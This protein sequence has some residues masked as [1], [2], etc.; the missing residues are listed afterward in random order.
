MALSAQL[1]RCWCHAS[2]FRAHCLLAVDMEFDCGC[3]V[4]N[5]VRFTFIVFACETSSWRRES[6]SV[7]LASLGIPRNDWLSGSPDLGVQISGTEKGPKLQT[8]P[9]LVFRTNTP[10]LNDRVEALAGMATV[11]IGEKERQN[12]L[13]V[14]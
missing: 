5:I 14:G 6:K 2:G 10:H 12:W 13:L 8:D 3:F 7:R 11:N 9:S 4:V 1:Q